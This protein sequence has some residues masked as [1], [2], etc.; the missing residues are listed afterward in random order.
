M[1]VYIA[2]PMRGYENWN[3]PAFE[4]ARQCW[5]KA[6]HTVFCPA[7]TFHGLGYKIEPNGGDVDKEHLCHVMNVDLQCVFAADAI[8]LLHGWEQS[9]GATVELA[10]AQF[11]KLQVYDAETMLPLATDSKPWHKLERLCDAIKEANHF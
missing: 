6:G 7:T 3:F 5:Q 9:S 10:L 8:A 11:L 4:R 1:K 2:G